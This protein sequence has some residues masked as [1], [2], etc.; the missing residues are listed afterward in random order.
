MTTRN[1]SAL[2]APAVSAAASNGRPEIRQQIAQRLPSGTRCT[3]PVG[4]DGMLHRRH[5]MTG[6]GGEQGPGLRSGP[7]SG[8]Q[9]SIRVSSDPSVCRG[10]A[11]AVPCPTV[12]EQAFDNEGGRMNGTT[13]TRALHPRH[14]ASGAIVA[15]HATQ[16][17]RGY[18]PAVLRPLAHDQRGQPATHVQRMRGDGLTP[19]GVRLTAATLHQLAMDTAGGPTAE[20]PLRAR[21][22]TPAGQEWIPRRGRAPPALVVLLYPM[23]SRSVGAGDG[24]SA[25]A[26]ARIADQAR[27]SESPSTK[28]PDWWAQ[29]EA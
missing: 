15:H 24:W 4:E 21:A 5:G 9:T 7:S 6:I 22:A 1:G 17:H 13:P 10:L 19:Q 28:P 3:I 26:R 12:F 11:R 18:I 14:S 29:N 16:H 2:L 27:A 23:A 8:P 20:P 25:R